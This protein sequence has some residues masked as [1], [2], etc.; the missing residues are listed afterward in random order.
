VPVSAATRRG[1]YLAI[2]PFMDVRIL[3]SDSGGQLAVA[4]QLTAVA[5]AARLAEPGLVQWPAS[6][7]VVSLPGAP[8]RREFGSGCQPEAVSACRPAAWRSPGRA[9]VSE[10]T[11]REFAAL[12]D[13]RRCW[14]VPAVLVQ[15]TGD[16]WTRQFYSGRSSGSSAYWPT[17]SR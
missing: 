15:A 16:Y 4:R 3:G 6:A 17:L 8:W 10:T 5:L 12:A 1:P 7:I 9:A 2:H 13:C 14:G 11:R